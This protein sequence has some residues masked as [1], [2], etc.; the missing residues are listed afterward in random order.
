MIPIN[1]WV[2]GIDC[3]NSDVSGCGETLIYTKTGAICDWCEENID[4]EKLS[5]LQL[6]VI[7]GMDGDAVNK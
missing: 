4:E 2:Q 3:P 6:E 5:E 1:E 7:K